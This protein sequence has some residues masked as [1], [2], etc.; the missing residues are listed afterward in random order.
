MLFQKSSPR[1]DLTGTDLITFIKYSSLLIEL[2]GA[3]L[4]VPKHTPNMVLVVTTVTIGS[5]G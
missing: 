3:D 2:G 4:P 5:S 1:R